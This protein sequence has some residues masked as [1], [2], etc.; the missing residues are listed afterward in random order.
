MWK[1]DFYNQHPQSTSHSDVTEPINGEGLE[2]LD[3]S[4]LPRNLKY[5]V[6]VAADVVCSPEDAE[7]CA[8]AIA[9]RL[10]RPHVSGGDVI[11]GGGLGVM[12]MEASEHRY[13]I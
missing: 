12:V 4:E 11:W 7:N 5:E 8:K 10:C 3:A 2:P 6:I 1:L 13:H 9:A